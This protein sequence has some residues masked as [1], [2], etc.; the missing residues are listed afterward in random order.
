MRNHRGGGIRAGPGRK[1]RCLL[2]EEPCRE[3]GHPVNEAGVRGSRALGLGCGLEAGST[4][5]AMGHM[6]G[7]HHPV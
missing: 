3:R 1:S 7:G 5:Q 6:Q 2:G 4:W